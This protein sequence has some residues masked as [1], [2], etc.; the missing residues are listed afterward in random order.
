M[1]SPELLTYCYSTYAYGGFPEAKALAKLKSRQPEWYRD[2]LNFFPSASGA[3]ADVGAGEG[4]L[5]REIARQDL[6]VDSYDFHPQ[7]ELLLPL[8]SRVRWTQADLSTS[9][10]ALRNDYDTV[11]CIAVIEH[12]IDPLGLM[13]ELLRI[14][15]PGGKV[16]VLGPYS[17]AWA[18]RLLRKRWPYIIPGEHLTIP[19]L[20]GLDLMAGILGCQITRRPIPVSY[21]V[22]YA[23]DATFGTNLP[24][25][26]DVML[27]L[28][29]GGF[30]M[31]LSQTS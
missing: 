10:W 26:M 12:L 3:I 29:V 9:G 24:P 4:W 28:P 7:P 23:A 5:S 2:V 22:K 14:A 20:Y 17:D 11:F 18:H 16:H 13:K 25:W 31:T 19:S 30:V 21:S 8:G 6:H 27:R 15:R 1:P